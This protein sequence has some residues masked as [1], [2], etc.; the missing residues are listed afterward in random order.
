MPS[1]KAPCNLVFSRTRGVHVRTYILG[2]T[3][4]ER[5]RVCVGEGERE[6]E[7]GREGGRGRNREESYSSVVGLDACFHVRAFVTYKHTSAF[8]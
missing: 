4:L 8:V 6:R 5:M 2:Y 7:K 1:K 3:Q